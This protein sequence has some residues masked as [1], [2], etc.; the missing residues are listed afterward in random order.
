ML[1]FEHIFL[2]LDNFFVVVMVFFCCYSI[3]LGV[4]GTSRVLHLHIFC[5]KVNHI[6]WLQSYTLKKKTNRNTRTFQDLK[7]AF[8]SVF[9]LQFRSI[10]MLCKFRR[11][12]RH[13]LLRCFSVLFLI[14]SPSLSLSYCSFLCFLA[15]VWHKKRTWNNN[16]YTRAYQQATGIDSL[17][18]IL[19]LTHPTFFSKHLH[20]IAQ[21]TNCWF[22]QG[23]QHIQFLLHFAM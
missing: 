21:H 20:R 16:Q 17:T 2:E 14:L 19:K 12:Y 4:F 15:F 13:E 1:H 10:K 23:F 11:I 6:Q 18:S 3:V 22:A 5:R 9:C 8:K 7:C